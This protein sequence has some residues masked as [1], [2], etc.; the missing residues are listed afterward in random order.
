[1]KQFILKNKNAL[2]GA[3]ALLIIAVITSSFIDMPYAY[4][5]IT[6][7][8]EYHYT[9]TKHCKDTV[10][11]KEKMSMEDFDKMQNDL[12]RSLL[13]VNEELEKM[14][15]SKMQKDLEASLKKIDMK[16]IQRDVELALKN[17]DMEKMMAEISSSLKELKMDTRSAELEKALT[18]AKEKI[19]KANAEIKNIDKN[20]IKKDLEKAKKD[21]EKA[22]LEI[23]KIDLDKIK[24]DVREGIDKAKAELK[25]TKE[26]FTAMENDG[27]IDTIKGF[28]IEYKDKVLYIDGKKQDEK[29]TDKY[30][31]YFKQD[32]FKITIDEN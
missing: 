11:V 29:T 15:F 16:K 30:R 8:D 28:S 5:K 7:L 6:G 22:R 25:L 27:L 14:D 18:E 9:Y 19:E 3:F 4:N 31:K 12:D 23:D 13:Q 10:P 1:M 21:I 2:A 32:N 26:M 17:I 20:A 24:V